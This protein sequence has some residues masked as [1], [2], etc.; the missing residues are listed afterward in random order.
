MTAFG[1][2]FACERSWLPSYNATLTVNL[3]SGGSRVF[4]FTEPTDSWAFFGVTFPEPIAN[5]IFDDGGIPFSGTHE[6]MLDNVTYGAIPEPS[7]LGLFALG[8]LFLR[9]RMGCKHS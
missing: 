3:A 9:W 4:S 5:V 6:E 1:A 7:V 8:G 2:D